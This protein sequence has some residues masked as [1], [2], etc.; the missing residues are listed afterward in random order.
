MSKKKVLMVF[1][2]RPE[3]IKMAPLYKALHA[4]YR[5]FETKVCVTAQ[6]RE[7]LDQV[8]DIFEIVPEIDLNIMKNGQSLTRL[9]SVILKEL[10]EVL[11]QEKPD[12]ILVHGD[13][14][15]TLSAALAGFYAGIRVAHVEAGLRTYN[16][17]SPFPEE[18]NRQIVGRLASRHFVPV[19]SSKE[20]LLREGVPSEKIF[21]TGNTVVDALEQCLE[22]TR[23]DKG[24]AHRIS[25][26]LQRVIGI[27]CFA[28]RIVLITGHRREN[29]GLGFEEICRAIETLAA[30]FPEVLYVFPVH[31]NP[32]VSGPVKK[33]LGGFQN[34]RLIEPLD[35]QQFVFLLANAYLVLTDSGGIQEEAPSLGKPV[36]VMRDTTERP[37][38]I[39]AGTAKLVGADADEIVTQVSRLLS[40]SDLYSTMASSRNPYGDG[41]ASQ[42]IVEILKGE[43]Y[44]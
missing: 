25:S 12:L 15:S 7:M 21:V 1:G 26:G 20:N 39:Q 10:E 5:T 29:F 41:L 35:Y 38:G 17:S 43:L 2:T 36:L 44:R 27:D 28:S 40:D 30:K 34:I 24:T 37:E 11:K 4:D 23:A 18:S 9:T 8:L 6:H 14:T 3:A 42:K 32:N 31:L 13:T 19:D 33:M 16:I 22:I